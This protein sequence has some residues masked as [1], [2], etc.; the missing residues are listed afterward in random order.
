MTTAETAACLDLTEEAVKVRLLRARRMLQRELYARVGATTAQAFQFLGWRCDRIVHR[1]FTNLETSSKAGRIRLVGGGN[2]T[3]LA[4]F[5]IYA[6]KPL[7][8]LAVDQMI[9][10]G[11]NKADLSVLFPKNQASR[12]FVQEKQTKAPEG[13]TSGPAAEVPLAGTSGITHPATGP[14]QGALSGALLGMGIPADEIETYGNLVAKDGCVLLSVQCHTPD[15]VTRA[16]D[17]LQRTGAEHI[18]ST[19][20]NR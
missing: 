8:E 5:G 19:T 9:K 17:L 4:V 18:S 7:V 3:D 13:I 14:V 20:E 1:V 11:F 2:M 12:E 16:K 6:T 10:D 15:E